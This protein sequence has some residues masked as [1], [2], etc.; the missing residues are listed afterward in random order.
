MVWLVKTAADALVDES[1]KYEAM[2]A[3]EFDGSCSPEEIVPPP[4]PL[5][6]TLREYAQ[7]LWECSQP[8]RGAGSTI[9]YTYVV[10]VLDPIRIIWADTWGPWV[11]DMV[12]EAPPLYFRTVLPTFD[13]T[14]DRPEA[15]AL[16]VARKRLAVLGLGLEN[17]IHDLRLLLAIDFGGRS[18]RA[19]RG[20]EDVCISRDQANYRYTL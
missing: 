15:S 14:H 20:F 4:A 12:W 6:E 9:Y 10:N 13:I 8:L 19:Y 7:T 1:A 5:A 2:E 17:D 3:C 18:G 16:K 11:L